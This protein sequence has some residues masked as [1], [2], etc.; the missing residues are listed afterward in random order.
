M[1]AIALILEGNSEHVAHALRKIGLSGDKNPIWT[2]HHLIIDALNRS[3]NRYCSKWAPFSVLVRE[4]AKNWSFFSVRAIKK[5]PIFFGFPYIISS[6]L[7]Y[8]TVN[9]KNQ[10]IVYLVLYLLWTGSKT[11]VSKNIIFN[12]DEYI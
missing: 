3:N 12:P 4:A 5:R 7:I 10:K 6:L 11:K 1:C 8:I 9:H 2:A